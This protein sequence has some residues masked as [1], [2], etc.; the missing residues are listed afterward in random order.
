MN[1]IFFLFR[2]LIAGSLALS[3]VACAASRNGVRSETQTAVSRET[4]ERF[5]AIVS[6]HAAEEQLLYEETVATS[7]AVPARQVAIGVP[8]A[9]LA[10]LPDGGRFA[11][12]HGGLAVEARRCGDSLVVAARSDSI[13]RTVERVER[14]LI[15][16][17]CDSAAVRAE[18]SRAESA[19]SLRQEFRTEVAASPRPGGRWNFFWAGVAVC[20]LVVVWLRRR[21]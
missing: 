11:G 20:A 4:D 6:S 17:R 5:S 1:P 8:L 10:A 16:S 3:A 15:R 19:D 13:P 12:R 7:E 14:T 2:R 21:I 9:A 18:A